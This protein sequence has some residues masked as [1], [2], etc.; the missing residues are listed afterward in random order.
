MS[1]WS[2][3]PVLD[4]HWNIRY[5]P[6]MASENSRSDL[7]IIN[8]EEN[9]LGIDVLSIY[10]RGLT[11]DRPQAVHCRMNF[12]DLWRISNKVS[13]KVVSLDR[14]WIINYFS[15]NLGLGHSIDDLTVRSWITTNAV[16]IWSVMK[17]DSQPMQFRFSVMTETMFY[18]YNVL[19]GWM[20][21]IVMQIFVSPIHWLHVK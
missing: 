9:S 11:H 3:I 4:N 7:C 8:F 16:M 12:T 2:R 21:I 1:R 5:M 17:L 13:H 19:Y 14:L 15:R 18:T 6:V 20:R 10:L